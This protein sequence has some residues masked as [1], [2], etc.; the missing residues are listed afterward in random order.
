MWDDD[1]RRR[2]EE[3]DRRR[4]EQQRRDEEDRRRREDDDR[5]QREEERRRDE[6][7]R[8]RRDEE[9]RR[10]EERREEQRREEQR[11]EEQ[12]RRDEEAHY[13]RQQEL[14]AA[15]YDKKDADKKAFYDNR[16][17]NWEQ[18]QQRQAR[19]RAEA[20]LAARAEDERLKQEAREERD[21][22]RQE[23]LN[24]AAVV[25]RR[26]WQEMQRE[27]AEHQAQLDKDD[28]IRKYCEKILNDALMGA[29]RPAP[30]NVHRASTPSA[31]NAVSVPP[32]STA[33]GGRRRRTLSEAS[34]VP[35]L[36]REGY[37]AARRKRRKEWLTAFLLAIF[38]AAF[39]TYLVRFDNKPVQ[40]QRIAEAP[41][42]VVAKLPRL[43]E[44]DVRQVILDPKAPLSTTLEVADALQHGTRGMGKDACLARFFYLQALSSY[45][46]GKT[47]T[48]N[49][50]NHAY[51]QASVTKIDSLGCSVSRLNAPRHAEAARLLGIKGQ[52]ARVTK[53][54]QGLAD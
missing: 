16:D 20:L 3:E 39:V 27:F 51:I 54:F 14:T 18:D 17:S 5:R 47:G 34:E 33:Q 35:L 6:E 43:K 25:A 28:P 46:A 12:R 8:R 38:M 1:D 37:L 26:R 50:V 42:T 2:R 41:T 49:Q 30:N 7:D 19:L 52:P 10:A 45:D 21:E 24:A 11:R 44:R 32:V 23:Q 36:T 53:A 15:A 48:R 31:P 13:R 4:E 9:Q 40:Q 29:G 22:R